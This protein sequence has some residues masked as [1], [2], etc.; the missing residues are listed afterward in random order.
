MIFEKHI[1]KH[2]NVKKK[3]KKKKKKMDNTEI[4][5]DNVTKFLG[6]LIDENLTWKLQIANTNKNF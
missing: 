2:P 1:Y 4:K 3:K 5:R 6:I